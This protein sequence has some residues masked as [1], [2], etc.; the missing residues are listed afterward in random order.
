[1][2]GGASRGAVWHPCNM[3]ALPALPARYKVPSMST[4]RPVIKGA[5]TAL[6]H[7]PGMVRYGSKPFREAKARPEFL[8]EL[9]GGLWGYDE[10]CRYLPNQV[11]IGSQA[12]ARLW[13]VEQPWFDK[14]ADADGVETPF[15][16]ILEERRFLALLACADP[17]KHVLLR[18]RFW[19]EIGPGA[20]IRAAHGTP[21]LQDARAAHRCPDGC[22]AG[23]L[24][25]PSPLRRRR[26]CAR[27]S[28]ED[29]PFRGRSALR[30]RAPGEPL[31]Q[32]LGRPGRSRAAEPRGRPGPERRRPGAELLGGGRRRPLPARRRQHGQGHRRVRRVR[33]RNRHRHQGL[34]RRTDSRH[35]HRRIAGGKRRIRERGRGRRRFASQARDEVPLPPGAGHP[36]A[37]RCAVRRGRV[38]RPGRRP[39]P[40]AE[41]S[42]GRPPSREGRRR[43]RQAVPGACPGAACGGWNGASTG[44]TGW[45]PSCTTRTLR[46]PPRP[47]T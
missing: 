38:D 41:P 18:E 40:D 37:G 11:F 23:V 22:R 3:A 26:R 33:P 42:G 39:Q 4:H 34:L 45:S 30:I 8:A 21:G 2:E 25:Q 35:G 1:M 17:F 47:A 10:A 7:T 46:F 15:G 44:S 29:G 28:R 5:A 32:G 31:L 6:A 27:G 9:T 19:E 36:R 24:G 16:H 43:P 14:L 13:E 20:G 12:P